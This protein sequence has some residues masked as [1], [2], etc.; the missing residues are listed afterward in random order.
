[1]SIRVHSELR[2]ILIVTRHNHVSWKTDRSWNISC[3]TW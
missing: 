2:L 1:M 3:A